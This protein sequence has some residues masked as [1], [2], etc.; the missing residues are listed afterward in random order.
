MQFP[1]VEL[2]I[3]S[4]ILICTYRSGLEITIKEAK[5]ILTNRLFF[6]RDNEYPTLIDGRLL[7]SIDWEARRFFVSEEGKKGISAA[8]L[9]ADSLL[10]A[11]LGNFFLKI[12]YDSRTFPARLFTDREEALRWLE[13]YKR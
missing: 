1:F 5:E 10:T 3:K 4:G 13:K 6:I 12:T 7:K 11:Y 2:E 9:L 8:A